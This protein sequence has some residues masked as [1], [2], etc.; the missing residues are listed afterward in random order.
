MTY[1][2]GTGKQNAVQGESGV[3]DDGKAEWCIG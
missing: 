3:N 2:E 1:R